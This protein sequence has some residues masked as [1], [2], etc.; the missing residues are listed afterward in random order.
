MLLKVGAGTVFYPLTADLY[1]LGKGNTSCGTVME[2]ADDFG[3]PTGQLVFADEE[4]GQYFVHDRL[5][6]MIGSKIQEGEKIGIGLSGDRVVAWK[7][8]KERPT[9]RWLASDIPLETAFTTAEILST[10][11][12]VMLRQNRRCS[13]PECVDPSGQPIETKTAVLISV[14]QPKN[15]EALCVDCFAKVHPSAMG[16]EGDVSVVVDG[17]K[18]PPHAPVVMYV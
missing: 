3:K 15:Y 7:K 1:K 14:S 11:L 17:R 4:S 8:K 13:H 9:G 6:A 5:L 12:G 2:L 16:P 10:F 18:L